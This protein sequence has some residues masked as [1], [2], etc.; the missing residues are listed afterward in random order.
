MAAPGDGKP[1]PPP[2]GK[3]G[4]APA[5]KPAAP[6]ARP[7][8]PVPNGPSDFEDVTNPMGRKAPSLA[9]MRRITGQST[10]NLPQVPEKRVETPFTSAQPGL[11]RKPSVYAKQLQSSGFDDDER[12][13]TDVLMGKVA[14]P[15]YD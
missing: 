15:L 12:T 2:Q 7:G 6:A 4:A 8:P 14:K 13:N 10:P 5:K 11:V 3:P 9:D 1:K